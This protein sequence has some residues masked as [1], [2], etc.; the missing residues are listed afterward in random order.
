MKRLM[1]RLS[2]VGL[3]IELLVFCVVSPSP[4]EE[5]DRLVEQAR[6]TEVSWFMWGGSPTINSWVDTY[7]AG[8]LKKRYGITLKRVPA[9][10]A[11]FVNKLLVEKQAGRKVGVMDLLWINGENFK[12]ARENGLLDGPISRLLPNYSLVDPDTVAFDFGYPVDGYE[13]PYGRAQFV[14]EYDTAVLPEPPQSLDQLKRWIMA[15]PG[16]FTYPRPPDFTGSAF[17]RQVFYGVSGG[18]RQYM[19]GFDEA[20]YQRNAEK[21]WDYLN[22]IKPYLWQQGRVYPK[23]IAALDNLFERGEVLL[24]MSYHQANAQSRIIQGR[25]PKTVRTFVLTDGSIYNTHF[26]A[27]PFNAPNRP[28]ALVVANFLLSPEAQLSKNQPANW[29][30]FTVLDLARL[31]DADRATFEALD[32]GAATLPLPVLASHGVP[33]IPSTYLERLERDWD[34][35]VLRGR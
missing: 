29:G 13:V 26:T 10:A 25:Y 2:V 33:E 32:L 20:L 19:S 5:F 23:D 11:V 30:D 17:V 9:D 18:Y 8:E 7:V 28:G 24:N 6:N 16:R 15:N 34:E 31:S 12:N 27:V 35:R 1:M 14:F 22:A 3:L 21:L 4:A